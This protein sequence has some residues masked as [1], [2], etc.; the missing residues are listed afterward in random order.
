LRNR[1]GLRTKLIEPVDERGYEISMS[2]GMDLPAY[3][4]ARAKEFLAEYAALFPSARLNGCRPD[5]NI[6]DMV[7]VP[8]DR[9]GL[10]KSRYLVREVTAKASGMSES[11]VVD[12]R[13]Q[14]NREQAAGY[15]STFDSGTVPELD[16]GETEDD[17]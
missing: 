1:I 15:N 8:L 17:L 12:Y 14:D 5:L 10:P 16:V 3:A 9:L 13:L 4:N 7:A 11:T 6:G 2:L